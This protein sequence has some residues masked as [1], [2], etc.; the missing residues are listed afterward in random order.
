MGTIS[1]KDALQFEGN[2][3]ANEGMRHAFLGDKVLKAFF[4]A[5]FKHS[6]F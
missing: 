4:C 6:I 3:F 1:I 5:I 2:P